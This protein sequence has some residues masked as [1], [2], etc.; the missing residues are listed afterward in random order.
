MTTPDL[1]V[2]ASSSPR[3][4][5]ILGAL[6]IPFVIAAADVDE[7]ILPGES[8]RDAA[9][10]LARAKAAASASLHRNAWVLAAD[11][12]V[13]IDGA[14]LGKPRDDADAAAMLRRLSG[15]EHV[16]VTA[17]SLL[18]NGGPELATA[19]ES[20][21]R[22]APLDE[23]EI[24]WY[25]ATGEPRDKAGAY[26]VQGLGARFVESVDGSFSNV[27]GLPARSV[28]RLLRRAPDPALARLALASE[29]ASSRTFGSPRP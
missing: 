12:L 29:G 22:I 20:R 19:E 14:V 7:T 28:Y 8:G 9:V 4:S 17:V 13:L 24:D 21:V 23:E 11:T 25:V 1:L 16:V 10:R 15:R 27:M 2:L 3:R 18:R 26:A 6:G 5:E